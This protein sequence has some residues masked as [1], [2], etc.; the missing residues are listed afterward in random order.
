[1]EK[2]KKLISNLMSIALLG[3]LLALT[4]CTTGGSLKVGEEVEI[5]RTTFTEDLGAG[6]RI[7]PDYRISPGDVLDVLYQVKSWEEQPDFKVAVDHI[8]TVRF[9][10][11]PE[12][13]QTQAVRPD[14][15][16]SLAFL[17][18]VHVVG[19]SVENLT[20]ELKEKYSEYLKDTE[21]YVVVEEFRGAIKELKSDLKTAPRG[22]SRL[23]TVRPDGKA[24]FA[25]VGDLPVAEKTVAQVT[26]VL[27]ERYKKI[28][29]GLSVD[30]F[31]EKHT[32][33]KIYVFGEVN[34]PGSYQ[35]LRPT[36]VFEAISLAGSVTHEARADSV[37]V[38][39][40]KN[41]RVLVTRVDLKA[42]MHPVKKGGWGKEKV[43]EAG[44]RL[45]GGGIFY[46][47]PDDIL[48]VSRR[49]LSTTA[50]IMQEMGDVF[51]F[52]GWGVNFGG[53]YDF[54]GN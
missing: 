41:E 15:K 38:F 32:G 37:F 54:G 40:Q 11:H 7:F 36:S 51:L 2:F 52:R 50:Q 31:L 19:R 28:L 1:M 25:M 21:L 6:Y 17:G 43:S 27:N 26:E 23:V 42:M 8:L 18:P 35:V 5:G 9:V 20:Q 24:T 34:Q 46:L 4:A 44:Y 22:L 39:R 16:I 47:H 3:T 33:S 53:G 29:P 12:L 14:G 10:Y 13:D 45:S 49:R 48:Y 30:V